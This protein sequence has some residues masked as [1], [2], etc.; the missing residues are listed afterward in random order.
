M[1]AVDTTAAG[2][3][4]TAALTLEYL[5]SGDIVRAGTYANIVGAL[6]VSKKGALPSLPTDAMVNKFIAEK[7]IRL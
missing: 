2:D 1:N 7:A 3:A 4:F 6:A 5:R